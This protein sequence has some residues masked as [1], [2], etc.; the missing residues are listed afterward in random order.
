MNLLSIFQKRKY[1][2]IEQDKFLPVLDRLI[3]LLRSNSFDGQGELVEK[4]KDDLLNSDIESFKTKLNS[5]DMWGGSGAVWEVGGFKTINDEKEFQLE[6]IKLAELM[7]KSGIK[8][9]KAQSIK[10]LFIRMNRQ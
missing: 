4:I 1:N 8:C 3:I 5:V 2:P 9:S 6:I 10:R 7:R